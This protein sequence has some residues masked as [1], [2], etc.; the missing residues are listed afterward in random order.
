MATICDKYAFDNHFLAT[1]TP[2]A[3]FMIKTKSYASSGN[4]FAQKLFDIKN[5]LTGYLI[6]YK[7]SIPFNIFKD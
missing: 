1:Q 7:F 6:N 3:K 4:K 2:K 5:I